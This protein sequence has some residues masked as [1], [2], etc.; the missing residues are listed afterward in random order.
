[1]RNEPGTYKYW[2]FRLAAATIPHVPVWLA[3]PLAWL[4]GLAVWA[5]RPA[6]RRRVGANLGH[7]PALAADPARRHRAVRGV[8]GHLALNYLDLFRVH[9]LGPSQALAGWHIDGQEYFDAALAEGRG[10]IVVAAHLGNFE[11]A[12]ARLAAMGAPVVL[13]VE[14]LEPDRLFALVCA[15]RTFHGIRPVP[16]D[17]PEGLRE[18]LA[19]LRR[20]EAVLLASDRDVLGTGI[21]VPFFGAPARLPTGPVLLAR[22]SGAPVIGAF[23][24]REGSGRSGGIFVPLDL[25]GAGPEGGEEVASPTGAATSSANAGMTSGTAPATAGRQRGAAVQAHAL[26]LVVRLLEERIAAHPEQWVAALAQ[27]WCEPHGAQGSD[28]A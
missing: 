27:I 28:A 14:R 20:G 25:T 19:A 6:T 22:R 15:L 12:A 26:G 8:F 17:R 9:R 5:I 4:V 24:W 10:V 2:A 11:Q 1:M 23:S 13:P 21:E 16:V 7:I 18:L 3:R